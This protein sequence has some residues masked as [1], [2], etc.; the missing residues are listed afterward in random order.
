[1]ADDLAARKRLVGDEKLAHHRD[2]RRYIEGQVTGDS[3]RTAT[4]IRPHARVPGGRN[5]VI[6]AQAASRFPASNSPTALRP[7]GKA[8]GEW[9]EKRPQ[10]SR[11]VSGPVA[12][13]GQAEGGGGIAPLSAARTGRAE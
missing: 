3:Q 2:L 6:G 11:T 13:V 4:M 1:M 12:R 8:G 10:R 5:G 7:C 9:C